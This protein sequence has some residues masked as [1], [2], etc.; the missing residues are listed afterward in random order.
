MLCTC[1][2][3]FNKNV[4]NRRTIHYVVREVSLL[5]GN[6]YCIVTNNKILGRY[7]LHKKTSSMA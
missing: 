6:L 7:R 2:N 4:K 5:D 1:D 3:N